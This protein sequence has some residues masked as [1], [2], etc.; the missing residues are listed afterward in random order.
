MFYKLFVVFYTVKIMY[1]CVFMIC[2]TSFCLCDTLMDP[3]NECV[4]VCMCMYVCMYM[5]VHV[6]EHFVVVIV[7]N[8]YLVNTMV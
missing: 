8:P 2:Y 7:R 6:L 3:W 1:I 5:C 4:C